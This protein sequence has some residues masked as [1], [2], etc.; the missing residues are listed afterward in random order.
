MDHVIQLRRL[1]TDMVN[2]LGRDRGPEHPL[3]DVAGDVTSAVDNALVD[4]WWGLLLAGN[5]E[6][7][8]YRD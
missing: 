5:L 1:L 3:E 2:R 8:I 4:Y 7:S 6:D